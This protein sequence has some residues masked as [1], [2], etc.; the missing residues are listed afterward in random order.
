M[1]TVSKIFFFRDGRPKQKS[2]QTLLGMHVDLDFSCS[3]RAPYRTFTS[4]EF[5][6]D[7]FIK[8]RFVCSLG[9]VLYS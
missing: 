7:G 2:V 8:I 4:C 9:S 3:A 1:L 6:F 5:F